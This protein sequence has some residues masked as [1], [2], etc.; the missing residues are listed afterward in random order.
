[1]SL[2]R[3]VLPP[4]QALELDSPLAF[5]RLD[6]QGRLAETGRADLRQLGQANRGMAVECYLHPQDSLLAS[7]ELPALPPAKIRA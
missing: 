6:R 7:L 5:A 2:L 3:I 1:M 4:L